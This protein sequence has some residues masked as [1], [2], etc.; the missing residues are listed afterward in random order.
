MEKLSGGYHRLHH[1]FLLEGHYHERPMSKAK[2]TY[3][4]GMNLCAVSSEEFQLGEDWFRAEVFVPTTRDGKLT[5][6]GYVRVG[7]YWRECTTEANPTRC[8]KVL[9][10]IA[11]RLLQRARIESGELQLL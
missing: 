4:N 8:P 10:S 2:L 6:S 9:D 3:A 11:N 1:A 5:Y 7:I